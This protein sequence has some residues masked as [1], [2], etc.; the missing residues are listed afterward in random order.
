[1]ESELKKWTSSF[2]YGYPREYGANQFADCRVGQVAR[3]AAF[4]VDVLVFC[5]SSSLESQG[6]QWVESFPDMNGLSHRDYED[7]D[8][9]L[10]AIE[11]SYGA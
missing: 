8:L 1:M 2:A 6:G 5:F 10:E 11:S 9:H 3:M 7:V 4:A